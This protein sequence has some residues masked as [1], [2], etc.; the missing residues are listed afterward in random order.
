MRIR[1]Q[2]KHSFEVGDRLITYAH[3]NFVF[4]QMFSAE[5]R[6]GVVGRYT[7]HGRRLAA[8]EYRP[9]RIDDFAQPRFLAGADA[10]PVRGQM[11]AA[12]R[13]LLAIPAAPVAAPAAPRP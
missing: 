7:F 1:G 8:V 5:T 3:G 4:D 13:A 12:S 2:Y 10:A 11:E 9:V 6:E